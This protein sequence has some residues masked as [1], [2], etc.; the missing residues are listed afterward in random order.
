MKKR[1]LAKSFKLWAKAEKLIPAGV[2]TLSKAPNQFVK[3]VTP[4]YLQKGKGAYVWD[5]DGNKYID[6]PMALGPIVLGYDYPAVTRAVIKQMHEGTTFTLPHPKEVELAELLIQTIPCAQMVRYGKN[7]ADATSAAIRAARAYTGRDH[8]AYCGYHGY[9][10]WF[11]IT[12][13]RNKGIPKILKNFAHEFVFNDIESLKKVFAKNP[14]K[15]GAVIMEIPGQEPKENF[16]QEV[17]NLAHKNKAVFIL[18][19][20]VTGF[21]YAMGGAAEYY[22]ITPDLAC[23]GKGVANGLP[24]SIIVG[25]KEIMKEFEEVFFSTT[26]GGDTLALAAAIATIKE[27]KSKKVIPYLWKMGLYWKNNFNKIAD[28]LGINAQIGGHGPR[29]HFIFKDWEGKDSLLAKSI[30]LQETVKRGILFGGPI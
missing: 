16:L 9:Q 1:K 10:D 6:Y 4:I 28:E 3:G 21:R 23:Y 18:D 25:K 27:L 19:E 24:L 7:G 22:K 17:I 5:V 2:Q 26:Y 20:I 11:A 14:N 15:I 8:F 12:T 30:F 29:T 13:Q